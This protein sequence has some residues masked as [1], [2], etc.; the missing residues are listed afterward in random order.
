[1]ILGIFGSLMERGGV[2][3]AGHHM[4]AGIA[5]LSR[6]RGQQYRIFA[7]NDAPRLHEARTENVSYSFNGFAR[8][9]FALSTAVLRAAREAE[10]AC[11]GHANLAPL[12][13]LVRMLNFRFRY[14]V[15]TYGI[16]VWKPL[17]RVRRLAL[18]SADRVTS[19]SS[20]TC[21]Q[22]AKVQRIPEN[23]VVLLPLGLD[24]EFYKDSTQQ[25]RVANGG[26]IRTILTVARLSKY[27]RYK[28]IDGVIHAMAK[29]IEQVPDVH[30]V[31]VGDGDDRRRLENLAEQNRVKKYVSFVGQVTDT[32]L[33]D[34]YSRCDLFVM[35]SFKEGFG[36]VFLEAMAFGKPVIGGNY[37]GTPDLIRDGINGFLI[38][39]DAMDVLAERITL[40]LRDPELRARMGE[41]GRRIVT[42]KHTFERFISGFE[43]ALSL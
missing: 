10:L 43:Q 19:I 34:Y 21:E 18:K 9:K 24:P 2:E 37:G 13:L 4:A 32:E 27:D 5:A 28:G 16:D 42:E 20:F 31:I 3:R 35:P 8:N 14:V 1:L 36:L 7:L 33:I 26:P 15:A 11:I 38:E 39:R 23:K 6:K 40:L 12:G 22:V 41:A 30:Y 29:V 17:S 25:R